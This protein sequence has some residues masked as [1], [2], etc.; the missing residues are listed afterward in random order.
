MNVTPGKPREIPR[1]PVFSCVFRLYPVEYLRDADAGLGET[2]L[3][4]LRGV[5]TSPGP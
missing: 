2:G 5:A 4:E 1:F 3:R